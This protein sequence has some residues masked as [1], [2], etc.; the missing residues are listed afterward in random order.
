MEGLTKVSATQK[1]TVHDKPPTLT[2][3]LEP[4]SAAGLSALITSICIATSGFLA[5]LF[6]GMSHSRCKKIS[7]CCMKCD[8]DVMTAEELAAESNAAA[9]A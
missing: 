7:C 4:M 8:R 3:M 6:R 5:V 9:D 1:R 2:H